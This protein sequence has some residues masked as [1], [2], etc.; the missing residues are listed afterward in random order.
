MPPTHPAP[1]TMDRILLNWEPDAERML[2]LAAYITEWGSL[3]LRWLHVITAIAWIGA[4]FFFMHLDASLRGTAT[5][6]AG[7]GGA[8]WQVHGGGFYEMR[9]Y[10]VAPEAMPA[11]LTWHKWQAYWTWISGF[12][13][14]V[15]VYY[16]QSQLYLINPAVKPLEPW[17]AAAFGIGGLLLGWLVYDALCRTLVGRQDVLLAAL[18]FGFVVAMS[19]VFAHLFSGRGAMLHTGA[20]MATM[21]AGNVAMNI[22]PNQRK[23]VADLVAGRTPNPD[24]GK[25]AKQRSIHNNYFT[26]PVL[27]F[28]LSNHYPTTYANQDT[29]PAIVVLVI[30]AGAVIRHFYNRRHADHGA[31]PWW[32][33]IVAAIAIWSA[34]YIAMASS[35]SGRARLGLAPLKTSAAGPSTPEGVAVP[36]RVVEIVS[37]RC[38]VCHAAEP[39]WEG[40]Q[41]APRNVRL[42]TPDAIARQ[43]DAIRVQAVLSHAM[44]PNN[45][46]EITPEERDVLAA[47]LTKSAAR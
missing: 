2:V 24:Y 25:Q 30:V 3:L 38:A 13:L 35:P 14:L 45:L 6:P 4:S 33:R 22:M 40:I 41:I 17:E 32:A 34:F 37:T 18:V 8:A 39:V 44:P 20:L 9:K 10:M 19:W 31:S 28:M 47:W 5:I 29:I 23:V 7:Q 16:G 1:E 12:F 21:M 42:D 26:L 36:T 43:A 15:W 46:T 27:F 11:E